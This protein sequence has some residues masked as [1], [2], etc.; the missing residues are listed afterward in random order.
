MAAHFTQAN[1]EVHSYMLTDI[2]NSLKSNSNPQAIKSRN[3]IFQVSST[4]QSQNSGGVLLFNIAPS[5]FSIT[6]GSM[7]LRARITFTGTGFDTATST[8]AVGLDGPGP[9]L[10]TANIAALGNGYSV[11]QRMT[12]YGSNSSIIAQHNYL[13]DEMNLMLMHNSNAAYL[14]TDASLLLGIG[15]QPVYVSATSS[16]VD[17][18]LP[19]PLSIFQSATQDFPAYLLS[20][21]L[22]L[23]IDLASVA[24]AVAVLGTAGSVTCTEYSV[25]NTFLL[26]QAIELPSALIEAE[27]MAVKSSPYVMAASSTLAVQVPQSILTS[28]TLGLNASSIRGVAIMPTGAASNSVTTSTQY[29]RNCADSV[30]SGG[31]KNVSGNGAGVSAQVYFDGNLIN[32]NIVDNVASS[33]YML[34]QM[35][36]H[37]V[38]GNILQ[39]SPI[40]QVLAAAAA[41]RGPGSNTY[42]QNYYSLGFDTTSFDE[43]STIF[44]GLPATNVNIQLAGYDLNPTFLVTILIFFDVLIAFGSEGSMSVKR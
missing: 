32:S 24:R 35:I 42:C 17:V 9:A 16:Y 34:K 18:V 8:A 4:S 29:Q 38:Q 11:M 3:R 20:A 2:P 6:K 5:N 36:H 31:S 40:A 15:S 19:V 28:Y 25:S 14:P 41:D 1:Q 37:C 26:F 10:A 33:F 43:E 7:A 21:P 39:P 30:I 44:G 23:Q 22:T 27:R 13:N 12:L